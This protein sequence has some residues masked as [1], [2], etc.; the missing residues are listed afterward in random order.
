M[1]R[2]ARQTVYWPGIEGDLRFYRS[3]CEACNT[4]APSQSPEALVLTPA[5]DYPFQKTVA[6]LFQVKG[7]TYMVYADRFTGYI[8]HFPHEPS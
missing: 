5:P 2:R 6:D 8:A 1:L 7:Q 3:S 4:H